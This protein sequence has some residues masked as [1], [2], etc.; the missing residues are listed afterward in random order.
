L[1]ENYLLKKTCDSACRAKGIY[2]QKFQAAYF[3]NEQTK[4]N[5]KH[6]I[7]GAFDRDAG[8]LGNCQHPLRAARWW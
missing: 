4:A 6:A 2:C 8:I 5:F 7:K 3:S 1:H